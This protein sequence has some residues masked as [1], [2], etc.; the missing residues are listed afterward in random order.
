[1]PGAVKGF[2]AIQSLLGPAKSDNLAVQEGRIT[3][4]L[5]EISLFGQA[6]DPQQQA[7]P[8]DKI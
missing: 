8:A 4:H 5:A 3:R 6:S 2:Q 7:A 1:M